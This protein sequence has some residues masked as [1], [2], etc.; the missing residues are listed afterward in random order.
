[1][2]LILHAG[3]VGNF[4]IIDEL[5]KVAKV[6]A[7]CGNVDVVGKVALLPGEIRSEIEG[8]TVYM[9]HVGGKPGVWLP[10][11]VEPKP[12]VVICG[13]SHVPLLE[14]VESTLFLNPGAA[15]TKRRFNIP[16]SAAILKIEDGT[17][18]GELLRLE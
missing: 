5:S 3:D 13:H 9:T 1:M 15:G 2:D 11:L 16:L 14:R 7:V 18:Q 8:V 6:Q 4:E 17:A 12:D 10:S